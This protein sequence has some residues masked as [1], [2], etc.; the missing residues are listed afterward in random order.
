VS[1]ATALDVAQRQ[2][3]AYNAQDLDAY[4]ACFT[5]DVVVAN[6]N[7]EEL[8]SGM[9]ALRQRYADLFS[10]HPLNRV[11]LLGRVACNDVV[12]DHERVIRSPDA[13]P[14]EVAAIYTVRGRL[15]CRIDF[16]R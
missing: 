4:C 16:V 11:V 15:I 8:W 6:F 1:T 9:A 12:V 3:D 7:G 2:L 13:E 5:D 10:Q 14:Y